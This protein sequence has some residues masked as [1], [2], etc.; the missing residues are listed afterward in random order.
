MHRHTRRL[1]GAIAG[2]LFA[3][4]VIAGCGNSGSASTGAHDSPQGAAQG[5]LTALGAYDGSPN[6]LQNLL[7]WVPPSKR[8]EA[9]QSFSGLGAAGGTTRFQLANVSIGSATVD[10]DTAKV[11]VRATL[12]ICVTGTVGSQSFS[13]CPPAPVSPNG[14]FDTLSCVRE[15]GQWYVADYSSSTGGGQTSGTPAPP[16]PDLGTPTPAAAETTTSAAAAST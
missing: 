2:A 11:G 8:A 4:A 10:G 12:S 3:I 14:T 16:P 1:L 7:D 6:S 13:T 5:F 9:Q 15:Q